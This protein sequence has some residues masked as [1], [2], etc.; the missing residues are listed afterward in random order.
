MYLLKG[1]SG[2]ILVQFPEGTEVPFNFKSSIQLLVGKE[3]QQFDWDGKPLQIPVKTD[4]KT[5][6]KLDSDYFSV[7]KEINPIPLWMSIIPPILAILLA[8]VFKEV[9]SS[10]LTGIFSGVAIVGFYADGFSGVIQSFFSIIDT[11]LLN[12]LNDKD[13]LSVIVFTTVIGG[14]VALVSKNGGMMG[15]VNRIAKYANSAKNAQLTTWFLGIIIFFDDY[16]NT[17]V[18]GNTMRPL[19]DRW[20]VSREKLSYLVDSTAAP[21][22]AIAFV[23]TWIGAELGYIGDGL[24]QINEAGYAFDQGPYAV[25]LSSLQYAYYPIFTIV[26]MYILIVAKKDFGPMLKAERRARTT[27]QVSAH[28][29]DADQISVEEMAA[30]EPEPGTKQRSVFAVVPIAVVIFGTLAGLILSGYDAAVWSDESMGLTRKLSI[31][32]GNANSYKS[33]LWSSLGAIFTAVV[34]TVG[35]KVMSLSKTMHAVINGFKFM[36][37]AMLILILAWTLADITGMLHTADFLQIAIA[38]DVAPWAVPALTFVLAGLVSFSTG[39]SWGTMAILYPII[40]P[41]TWSV[42]MTSGLPEADALM[43]FYN[44]VSCVLAG[45]VLGDHCSPISD[46]TILSSMSSS[47]NHIDHVNTQMPYALTVGV[48]AIGL[49]T[50]PAALGVPGWL[51]MIVGI[52]VLYFIVKYFGKPTEVAA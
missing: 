42:C 28:N 26:F 32:I 14:V 37:H 48:I 45:S 9:L 1:I 30:Y 44:T 25:F 39:S 22:A 20:K 19:T 2:E 46:T 35:F 5:Q 36:M 3:F 18:V 16:A 51:C 41:L 11:H 50:V 7:A 8:L 29:A 17:L 34:M 23:T 38:D 49:G 4:V 24:Q 21:V 6:L 27:G 13:R 33:L 10:L 31:T 15:V 52:A 40:L 43:I 47:C 12:A